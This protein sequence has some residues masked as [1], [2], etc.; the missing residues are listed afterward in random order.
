MSCHYALL[1]SRARARLGAWH[2]DVGLVRHVLLCNLDEIVCPTLLCRGAVVPIEFVAA[3]VHLVHFGAGSQPD[4][5]AANRNAP[6]LVTL[7]GRALQY[8]R[9][10]GFEAHMAPASTSKPMNTNPHWISVT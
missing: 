9:G 10:A 3:V 1:R 6:A 5:V 7:S 2:R 8:V 4:V